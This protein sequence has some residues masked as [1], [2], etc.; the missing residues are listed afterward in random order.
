MVEKIDP[1]LLCHGRADLLNQGMILKPAVEQGGGK[2]VEFSFFGDFGC[3]R[4]SG[5]IAVPAPVFFPEHHGPEKRFQVI[6][7]LPDHFQSLIRCI[8]GKGVFSFQTL[9]VGMDIVAIEKPHH[10]NVHVPEDLHRIDGAGPAAGVQQQLHD[11]E[12]KIAVPTRTRVAPS[13]MAAAKSWL[14]PMD[15]WRTASASTPASR[16]FSRICARCWK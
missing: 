4:K 14:I 5:M 1:A 12:P 7:R 16:I 3:G 8:P 11:R 2:R 15:R 10:L 6:I 9:G 13:W